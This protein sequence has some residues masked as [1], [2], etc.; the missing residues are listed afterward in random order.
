MFKE[1]VITYFG[2]QAATARALGIKQPSVANWPD[3]IPQGRAYQIQ[4]IT[5]NKLIVDPLLYVKQFPR[6]PGDRRKQDAA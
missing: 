3:I 1:T 5:Y 4:A 6:I 2:G